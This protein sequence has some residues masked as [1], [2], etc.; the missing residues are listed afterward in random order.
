MPKSK[1]ILKNSSLK[2]WLSFLVFFFAYTKMLYGYNFAPLTSFAKGSV[3]AL[4]QGSE[5]VSYSAYTNALNKPWFWICL[6]LW[7]YQGSKYVSCPKNMSFSFITGKTTY[8]NSSTY[9][10]QDY[11]RRKYYI[12]HL[13]IT[14]VITWI[15][16]T[17][18]ALFELYLKLKKI[19]MIS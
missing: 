18:I 19:K 13:Q 3:V 1:F 16:V 2:Y 6:W 12:K 7:T 9:C 17:L 14:S 10:C 8:V 15:Y 4:W 11:Y 5:Y